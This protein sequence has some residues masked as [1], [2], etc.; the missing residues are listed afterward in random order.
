M[1][2]VVGSIP[3]GSTIYGHLH[4]SSEPARE[5]RFRTARGHNQQQRA[6]TPIRQSAALAEPLTTQYECRRLDAA[7]F[8]SHIVDNTSSGAGLP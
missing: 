4:I 6:K 1:Q 7:T 8:I 3:S 5:D 2:E